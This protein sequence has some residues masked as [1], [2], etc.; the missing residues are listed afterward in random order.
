MSQKLYC[1]LT[2]VLFMGSLGTAQF[3]QVQQ[4]LAISKK[5]KYQLIDKV[6]TIIKEQYVF[7]DK[8]GIIL[9]DI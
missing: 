1:L 2:V 6:I 8:A 9:T 7:A 3:S 4:D 5:E